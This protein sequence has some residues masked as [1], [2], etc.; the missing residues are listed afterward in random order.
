MVGAATT[1]KS[2]P[3]QTSESW[4]PLRVGGHANLSIT[5]SIVDTVILTFDCIIRQVYLSV[6]EQAAGATNLTLATIDGPLTI[7]ATIAAVAN[8]AA[9]LQTLDSA[10]DGVE[11]FA[12]DKVQTKIT[13]DADSITN[14][15]WTL[16]LEAIR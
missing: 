3:G 2:Y 14:F 8:A 16:M 9:V 11:L 10:I 5:A 7:V 1:R 12:G 15:Q 6:E 4:F 13:T